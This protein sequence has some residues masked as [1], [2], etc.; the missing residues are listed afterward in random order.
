M[1]RL[2]LLTTNSLL[3]PNIGLGHIP[4]QGSACAGQCSRRTNVGCEGAELVGRALIGRKPA[5]FACVVSFKEQLPILKAQFKNIVANNENYNCT[6]DTSKTRR[7]Q[8]STP[9]RNA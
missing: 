4:Q 7:S 5:K 3:T 1:N 8:T 9:P 6:N 2:G